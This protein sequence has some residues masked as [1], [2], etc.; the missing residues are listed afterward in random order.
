MKKI[1][2]INESQLNN[3]IDKIINEDENVSRAYVEHWQHK[4]EKSTE[5]LLKIGYTTD[6]L[7]RKIESIANNTHNQ[8]A[9]NENFRINGHEFNPLKIDNETIYVGKDGILGENRVFI[10]WHAIQKLLKRYKS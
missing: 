3:L 1:I 10:P 6:D 7:E 9:I 5:V 8:Y 4:F 2:K